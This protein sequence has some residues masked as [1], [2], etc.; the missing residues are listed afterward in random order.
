MKAVMDIIGDFF[1]TIWESVNNFIYTEYDII[2]LCLWLLAVAVPISGI[3]VWYIQRKRKKITNLILTLTGSIL[4]SVLLMKFCVGYYININADP[5]LHMWEVFVESVLETLQTFSLD[6]E[7]TDYINNCKN[8]VRDIFGT[9]GTVLAKLYIIFVYLLNV[10]APILGGAILFDILA[11]IF[12]KVRWWFL[13]KAIWRPKYYFSELNSD[14]LELAKSISSTKSGFFGKPVIIFTDVYSNKENEVISE[15][16]TEAKM[17]GTICISDDISHI[18]KNLL[19]KR[20]YIL[21][22]A[23]EKGNLQALADLV[24]SSNQKY[25]KKAE[26]Y[27]FTNDDAYVQIENRIR[28]TLNKKFKKEK[29]M[30]SI[31]PI[32]SYR[33][34]VSNLLVEVPLYEP[35][36]GKK[37]DKDGKVDLNVAIIGTGQIGMEMFLSTYW[38]GQIL[39]C[40]LNITVLSKEDEK[41]FYGRL[42]YINPE[43]RHTMIDKDPIL[44][45]NDKGDMAEKYCGI[46]YYQCDVKS[47]EFIKHLREGEASILNS[48]YFFVSLGSDEINIE[49]ADMVR[50]YV[51]EHH[52]AIV[53][54]NKESKAD[55]KSE[56]KRSVIA[57]VV[58]DSDVAETLNG[59]KHFSHF[60]G[61]TDVYM[62]AIGDLRDVYSVKNVFL[63]EYGSFA[64]NIHKGYLSAKNFDLKAKK[65]KES[66]NDYKYWANLS[67]AMHKKYRAFALGIIPFSLLD[68][69]DEKDHSIMMSLVEEKY[70]NIARGDVNFVTAE[71]WETHK[72]LIHNL[73]WMEH[74]RWNAFTRIKGFRQTS[75]YDVY[76]VPGD[77]GSYKH[78]DI[79][80][81]PCLVE[82]SK[83][84]IHGD[85]SRTG[86]VN[87]ESL[88]KFEKNEDCDLLD[89][90]TYELFH[91][92]LNNYDF[93]YYDYLCTEVPNDDNKAK[94]PKKEKKKSKI[95]E[96]VP[97]PIDTNGVE[98][99]NDLLMLK[100]QIAENVHE[101]WSEGRI[102]DGWKYGK[103]RNDKKKKTPCLVPYSKLENKEKE[104]DRNTAFETLKVIIKL[105]YK[106]EKKK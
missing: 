32:H 90:L 30:P 105:G 92:K 45:Y 68:F 21:I 73:A 80:L 42:D 77:H 41:E 31:L 81:H 1:N 23:N 70:F 49:V 48:D 74:R 76:G 98:L 78:M 11:S 65:Y 89:V 87:K 44:R 3:V 58:Y 10:S 34:I 2:I 16:L 102:K 8:I 62:R 29:D 72:E 82:C 101:N 35:L 71:D 63:E 53:K 51:G 5:G 106:I 59:K 57:Y 47:S 22:D 85:M 94:K 97:K 55:E 25:L 75:D 50:R 91:D 6:G 27:L 93:K 19:G 96:Y 103:K 4:I 20:K 100:E 52:I 43:I 13:R 24:I 67:R 66:N 46:K 83:N 33:N 69:H 12:P 64:D 26:V 37:R 86:I 18:K 61:Y 84:G 28:D 56:Q 40:N 39:N 7:Y 15:V 60:G 104:Y 54:E 9:E 99:P 36:I 14:S 88:L 17:L 38:F 79:K 95:S